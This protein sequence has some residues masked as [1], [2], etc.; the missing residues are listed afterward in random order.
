MTRRIKKPVPPPIATWK[1]V[2]GDKVEIISGKEKPINNVFFFDGASSDGIV[3]RLGP[4]FDGPDRPDKGE[5][6]PLPAA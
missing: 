5:F 3:Q 4:S 6:K 2:R 1:V